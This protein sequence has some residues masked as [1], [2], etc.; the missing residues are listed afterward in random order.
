MRIVRPLLIVVPAMFLALGCGKSDGSETTPA[1]ASA[2][3]V[4]AAKPAA[5]VKADKP[6]KAAKATPKKTFPEAKRVQ[7]V[8]DAWDYLVDEKKGYGFAVPEGTKDHGETKG[9]VD[10]YLA[11][12]PDPHKVH[13]F[14]AAYKDRSRTLEDLRAD[15]AG[16]LEALGNTDVKVGE[17]EALT[18]DYALAIATCEMG[19]TAWKIK[20]LLATDV[21]DNYVLMVGAPESDFESQEATIDAVWGSFAMFSGGAS[22][23]S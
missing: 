19:G 3:V 17:A 18:P 6:A 10:L 15:A 5:E 7:P 9:G 20:V 11:E 14:A 22:G 8:P 12:L 1:A 21:T 2:P 13:V 4:A 16:V 23:G